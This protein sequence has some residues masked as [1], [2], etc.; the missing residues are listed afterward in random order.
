MMSAFAAG[1]RDGVDVNLGVGYVDEAVIPAARLAGA[2]TE[3]LRQPDRYRLPFNYGGPQGSS[4][5]VA[6]LKRY[7]STRRHG[8]VPAAT[9]EGLR[10]VIGPSGVTSLL[11]AV[12]QVVEPG[13]VVMSDPHYYIYRDLLLRRGFTLL[14]VPEDAEG[15]DTALLAKRLKALGKRAS[16]VRFLFLVTVNNPTG[17]VLSNRRRREALAIAAGLSKR[18]RRKVPVLFDKAY[19]DLV[20]DPALD[21]LESLA[22]DRDGLVHELGSLSKVLAPALRVGYLVGPPSPFLDALV[23]K[24][25]DT[26]FSAPL[27]NQEVASWMLDHHI[28][29]QSEAALASYHRK[30]RKVRMWIEDNLSAFLEEVRGGQAGF[31]YYL[32]FRNIATVEGGPLHR[33]LSRT[34]GDEA[35]DG[36]KANSKPRVVYLPGSFCVD[37]KGAQAARGAR[38]MRI[39]Y[40]YEPEDRIREALEMMGTACLHVIQRS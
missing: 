24:T 17:T 5:L 37:P 40:A 31:Y 22:G 20:H 11:E 26:G 14:A 38:S 7:L 12:A 13:I 35:L 18:L 28:T 10:I 23:Q 2:L 19:E 15:L 21:P 27:M 3:V 32:T 9:L 16:K 33:V 6:S 36:P 39:S 1:F 34:T 30:A 4:N 8:P 29:E 25:S